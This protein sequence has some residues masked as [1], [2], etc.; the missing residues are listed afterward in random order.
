MTKIYPS[1]VAPSIAREVFGVTS[2]TLRRWAKEGKIDYIKTPGG[3]YRYNVAGHIGMRAQPAPKP[4]A[5]A[6]APQAASLAPLPPNAATVA[7]STAQLA[8]LAALPE[9]APRRRPVLPEGV[10]MRSVDDEPE[11]SLRDPDTPKV[12]QAVRPAPIEPPVHRDPPA[13]LDPAAL[14]QKIEALARASATV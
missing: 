4:K 10:E 11:V 12:V 1:F 13:K 6:P 8:P 5:T 7:A 2:Q 3:Q 9:I 14:A